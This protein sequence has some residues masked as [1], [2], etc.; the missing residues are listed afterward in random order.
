MYPRVCACGFRAAT[1]ADWTT[2]ADCTPPR[3]R[4]PGVGS[5]LKAEFTAVGVRDDGTCGCDELAALMDQEGPAWC[6]A[7]FEALLARLCENAAKRGIR[8]GETALWLMLHGA[9][10]AAEFAER[11]AAADRG[12]EGA[13]GA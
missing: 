9:I 5:C 4:T 7:N 12:G 3:H 1:P 8:Y 2:I 6:R 10:A 11:A 13:S